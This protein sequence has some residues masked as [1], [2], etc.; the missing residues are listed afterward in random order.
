MHNND[1]HQIKLSTISD[2]ECK[3]KNQRDAI[4]GYAQELHAYYIQFIENN[5]ILENRYGLVCE[6]TEHAERI[7]T[8]L[9][10]KKTFWIDGSTLQDIT[11][12]LQPLIAGFSHAC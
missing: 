3:M 6:S 7:M 9:M 12:G 10:L 5:K 11:K 8:T 4:L 1:I 2:R